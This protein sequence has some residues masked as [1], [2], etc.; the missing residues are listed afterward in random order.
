[1]PGTIIKTKFSTATA[2]PASDALSVGEQAYSFLT[3][4]SGDRLYIGQLVTSGGITSVEAVQIGGKYYTDIVNAATSANTVSTLV[5]RDA[6]GNFSAGTIS[7]ALSG[8]ATT[9]TTWATPRTLSLTGDATASLASVDG[10]AAVS[11]ALT[12]AINVST[13]KMISNAI[14]CQFLSIKKPVDVMEYWTN[15]VIEV[16]KVNKVQ[17]L[18]CYSDLL[19]MMNE[20]LKIK[21]ADNEIDNLDEI[22]DKIIKTLYN[23][24]RR[25]TV[26]P[27]TS[28]IGNYTHSSN[29]EQKL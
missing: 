7:A 12:L 14:E 13:S 18:N 4:G 16:T 8:N 1:M 2:T 3:G 19:K 22:R 26:L 17:I 6:S 27:F 15:E 24:L 23:E 29:K 9:A 28:M 20:L 11:A 21:P 10:S 25:H 5:K